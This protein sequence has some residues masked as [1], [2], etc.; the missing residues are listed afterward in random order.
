MFIPNPENKPC[1]DHINGNK[2]DNNISN[3]RWSTHKENSNNP[4]T[5]DNCMHKGLIYIPTGKYYYSS[6][7]ASKDL[8]IPARTIRRQ[9]KK[10]LLFK[11]A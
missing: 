4:A 5:K 6:I 8:G 1:V 3:L 2:L 11:E 7:E 9:R 10:G